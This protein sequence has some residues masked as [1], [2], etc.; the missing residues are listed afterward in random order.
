MEL[1]ITGS[2]RDL[3]PDDHVLVQIDQVLDPGWLRAEPNR[4]TV[5]ISLASHDLSEMDLRPSQFSRDIAPTTRK[6][7]MSVC[8]AL[9]TRPSRS[10]PP[11]ECWRGT[12]PS[13]AAKSRP[14]RKCA[15]LGA[16]ASTASAISGP[17]PGIVCCRRT[18][19]VPRRSSRFCAVTRFLPAGFLLA[20]LSRFDQTI[21]FRC[22]A[23]R[24][25]PSS[26]SA[27]ANG[28]RPGAS[29]P[30]FPPP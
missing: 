3:I 12:R 13:R 26:T 21:S 6:P 1:F 30:R 17:M 15:M 22:S 7:R 4:I 11:E 10:L 2:L 5:A 23:A 24:S 16:N 27:M 14:Q 18:V 28:A 20:L 9:D 29:P 8:P 25:G 19:S